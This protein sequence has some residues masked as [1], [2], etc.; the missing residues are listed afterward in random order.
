MYL[1]ELEDNMLILDDKKRTIRSISKCDEIGIIVQLIMFAPKKII[2]NCIN[3]LS[4]KVSTLIS[5]IFEDRV[6]VL[7]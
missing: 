6:S 7:L 5:Y 1:E 4:K 3:S 2:I